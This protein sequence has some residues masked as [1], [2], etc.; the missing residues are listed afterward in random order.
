MARRT[1][2]TRHRPPRRVK[3]S[4]RGRAAARRPQGRA[5]GCPITRAPRTTRRR[6]SPNAGSETRCSIAVERHHGGNAGWLTWR[7]LDARLSVLGSA[8]HAV[9]TGVWRVSGSWRM[10]RLYASQPVTNSEV[11]VTGSVWGCRRVRPRPGT[12]GAA[13]DAQRAS[14]WGGDVRP[15]TSAWACGSQVRALVTRSCRQRDRLVAQTARLAALQ[16]YSSRF[17]RTGPGPW[18]ARPI[19]EGAAMRVGLFAGPGSD[20]TRAVE[21]ISAACDA[22]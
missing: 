19:A 11:G 12:N 14:Q 16:G 21:M 20:M 7:F 22:R 17:E 5:Y 8:L 3:E 4:G 10:G 18:L 2:T 9:P 13:R 6:V 15:V 1:H